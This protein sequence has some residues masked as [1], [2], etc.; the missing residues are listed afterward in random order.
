LYPELQTELFLEFLLLLGSLT[1]NDIPSV[2][3]VP[4]IAGLP[5][6]G[7]L[8]PYFES[9]PALA[10]D[11]PVAGK[12]MLSSLI[13]MIFHLLISEKLLAKH[14]RNFGF[15]TKIIKINFRFIP[16][17]VAPSCPA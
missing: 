15:L 5:A 14:L 4:A 1:F 13:L 12:L 6:I 7:G 16:W 10:V 8:K 9:V 3:D 2:V 17:R 11:P